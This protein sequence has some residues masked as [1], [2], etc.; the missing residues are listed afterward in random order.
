MTLAQIAF[1]QPWAVHPHGAPPLELLVA[2]SGAEHP[3]GIRKS[4]KEGAASAGRVHGT[5]ETIAGATGEQASGVH[6]S[7]GPGQP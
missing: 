5:S 3:R 7:I 6:G 1:A 2:R 4:T